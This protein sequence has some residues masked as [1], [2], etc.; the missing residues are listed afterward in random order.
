AA[1]GGVANGTA[2]T[3]AHEVLRIMKLTTLTKIAAATA[4]IV[5]VAAGAGVS[6]YEFTRP[7]RV[8]RVTVPV[9]P[10]APLT[11]GSTG[12]QSQYIGINGRAATY[13]ATTTTIVNAGIA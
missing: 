2:F 9:S 6:V 12:T 3:L 11:Q 1:G 10:A 7:P 8:T 4:A 13:N 5:I